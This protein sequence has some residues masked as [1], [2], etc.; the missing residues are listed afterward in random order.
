MARSASRVVAP[1]EPWTIDPVGP[2]DL[3]GLLRLLGNERRLEVLRLLA[4]GRL[5]VQSIARELRAQKA[6]I[7]RDLEALANVGLVREDPDAGAEVY[8]LAQHA[9]RLLGSSL[10]YGAHESHVRRSGRT[11]GN[12]L[13]TPPLACT[14][15]DNRDY[16]SGVLGERNTALHDARQYHSQLKKM[17]SQVLNAHEAERKRIARELHD[18]TAQALTSI[19]VR[20]RLL[21]RSTENGE[22]LKNVEELRDLTAGALDSVRRMAMDLRPA[23]LDDLGL[24]PAL[25]AY[26]ENY[27]RNWPV[28][29]TVSADGLVRR[30]PADVELVLYRVVQEALTNI[31]KHAGARWAQVSLSRR[32][33]EVTLV[34]EDDGVGFDPEEKPRSNGTG[35]GHFGM[36]ERLALV[37]GE[38][39]I[40]STRGTGTKVTARVPLASRRG[41][42]GRAK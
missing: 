36:R 1:V 24:V 42:P 40:E 11:G 25:Q 7:K 10:A 9:V 14:I 20:L 23:A 38:L 21:E 15:C 31:A 27:S 5:D 3:P 17:S 8:Q 32:H 35:L 29:V 19:L 33:N 41:G 22:V 28:K 18:D 2:R 16:V 39:E 4:A 26:A 13:R 6:T 12:Q 37:E 30:V 34:V